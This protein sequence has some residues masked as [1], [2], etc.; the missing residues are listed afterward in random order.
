MEFQ[1]YKDRANEHRWRLRAANGKTIADSA[2]GYRNR[3]D[4]L[5]AIALVKTCANA[6]IKDV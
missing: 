6:P 5:A 2:E 1:I 3:A 4:C